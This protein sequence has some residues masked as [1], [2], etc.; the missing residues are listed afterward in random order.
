[1]SLENHLSDEALSDV[2]IGL[3]ALDSQA[4]LARCGECRARVQE[5]H[6][7]VSLFNQASLAWSEALSDRELPVAP[8]YRPARRRFVLAAWAAAATIFVLAGAPFLR[9]PIQFQVPFTASAPSD[10]EAQIAEDNEFLRAVDAAI[11]PDEQ[12]VVSDYQIVESQPTAAHPKKRA[13]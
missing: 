7:G 4:H 11:N 2:L 3:A 8:A 10:S 5:F 1:M 6:A 9:H 13:E 12:S